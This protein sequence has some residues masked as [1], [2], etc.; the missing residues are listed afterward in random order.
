MPKSQLFRP[1]HSGDQRKCPQL[2]H[3]PSGFASTAILI[4][5]F[6]GCEG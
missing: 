1:E 2:K 3:P 6:A 5:E 4:G